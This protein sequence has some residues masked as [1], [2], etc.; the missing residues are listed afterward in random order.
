ITGFL[1]EASRIALVGTPH[2]ERSSFVGFSLAHFFKSSSVHRDFWITHVLTFIA[3]LITL[4]ATKLRHAVTA[5]TNSYFSL[6][7]RPFGEAP[8]VLNLINDQI[9]SVGASSISDFSWKQL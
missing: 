5:P 6:R 2:F 1:T 9:E 8:P 4:P 3:F 7:T